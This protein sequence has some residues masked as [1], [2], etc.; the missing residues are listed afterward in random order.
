MQPTILLEDEDDFKLDLY[1][2]DTLKPLDA[3]E[4]LFRI[5]LVDGGSGIAVIGDKRYPFLSPCVFVLNEKET[6][7]LEKQVGDIHFH[8]IAFHPRIINSLFEYDFIWGHLSGNAM[9][10]M[11]QDMFWLHMFTHRDE[12][13]WGQMML[14]PI[15]HKKTLLLITTVEEKLQDKQDLYWICRSRSYFIELLIFLTRLF[16]ENITPVSIALNQATELVDDIILF[17]H[18]NYAKKITLSDITKEFGINRTSVNAVFQDK[19]GD[20]IITYLIRLRMNVAAVLLKDTNIPIKDISDRV[21]Y[22]NLNNF[23]RAFKQ[24]IGYP[25]AQYREAFKVSFC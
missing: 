22:N 17:L 11:I 10:V 25:P 24:K 15:S 2:M 1:V 21:G 7:H 18:A 5:V 8:M 19:T 14:N 13:N 12:A 9:D 20:T 4:P 23:S 3:V 16:H 6:I